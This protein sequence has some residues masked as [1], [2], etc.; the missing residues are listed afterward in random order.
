MKVLEKTSFKLLVLVGDVYQIES[1]QFGNWFSIMRTF[2]PEESVFELT[3]P[4]RTNNE[5]LIDF[6][7]KV[8]HLNDGIEESIAQNNY[9]AVLDHSL[10][11]AQ[12]DDE[13]ILCLNYDGLYG[14]N[15][16][17]RFLQSSNRGKEIIWGAT[18][19]KVGDPVL[20]NDTDRFKP[21]IFNNLKG[22]I[23]DI[24]AYPDRVQF[25]VWLDRSVTAIDV[26][27]YDLEY[28]DD[29]TV[30]FDV[31]R[32]GSTDQDDESSGSSVPF[33]VAYAVSI[34]KAQG[35][36]YDSVQVVITDANEDDISHNIF[37]TAITRARDQ[38]KIF[39][40]PE[41]QHAVNGLV[42]K[43]SGKDVELLK[44]R[45]GVA[46]LGSSTRRRK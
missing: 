1:I 39:W 9:S 17:N 43:G 42:R 13:I 2:V 3:K 34:H 46:P 18:V 12:R 44:A 40:T 16:V 21:L 30:R 8:R 36:E 33:Q 29:S 38:L 45:R 5:A 20:F 32:P 10:F 14:I 37:Y 22:K 25:D 11:Q 19:Y 31:Y 26:E 15:N 7:S 23:V 24:V 28:V 27:G 41:T 4:Y 35:L 6:W